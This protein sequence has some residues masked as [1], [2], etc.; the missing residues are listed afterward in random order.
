MNVLCSDKTGTLTEGII[1]IQSIVDFK[2]NPSPKAQMYAYLNAS[3][4]TGFTNSIDEAICSTQVDVSG[5]IKLDEVPY[6]FIRKRLSVLVSK[7]NKNLIVTKGALQ[8]RA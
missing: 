4:Q 8:K 7:D 5:Y 3:N 6:D 2:G 1:K